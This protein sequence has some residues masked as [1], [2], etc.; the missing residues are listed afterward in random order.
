VSRLEGGSW[1]GIEQ[2]VIGCGNGMVSRFEECDDGNA[3][4]GDG[5]S[6]ACMIE[7]TGSSPR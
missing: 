1:D 4:N 5:C 7:Q 2:C 6:A 3:A